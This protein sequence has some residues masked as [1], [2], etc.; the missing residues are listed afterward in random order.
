MLHSNYL[1]QISSLAND[2]SSN[3]YWTIKDV[4]QQ[5]QLNIIENVYDQNINDFK[6]AEIGK[7]ELKNNNSLIRNDKNYWLDSNNKNLTP[8]WKLI[9]NL[10]SIVR[11]ELFLPIKRHETQFA[12]YPPGH[13]YKR[14]VDKHKYMPSRLITM[15]YYI[16]PWQDEHSGELIVYSKEQIKIEPHQ[17]SLVLFFSELEHEVLPTKAHRK[18]LTTWFRDDVL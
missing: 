1:N 11:S 8:V 7:G 4:F 3:G 18:S 6:P 9:E 17:N 2:L 16:S 14:H 10:T 15:V 5:E 12:L 13:F